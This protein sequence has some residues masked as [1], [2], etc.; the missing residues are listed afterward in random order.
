MC[1]FFTPVLC[2]SIVDTPF[3]VVSKLVILQNTK[4]G[5]RFRHGH[6]GVCSF[7][8]VRIHLYNMYR[9][10]EICLNKVKYQV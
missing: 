7:S 3:R 1:V 9:F 10:R 6:A 2:T 5:V 8:C 4:N